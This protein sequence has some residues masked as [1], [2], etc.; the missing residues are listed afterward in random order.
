[1]RRQPMTTSELRKWQ[2]RIDRDKTF[3]TAH[4]DE[5][6]HLAD[7]AIAYA[8]K[9]E[10][11]RGGWVD[12]Y[13]EGAN[14]AGVRIAEKDREIKRLSRQCDRITAHRD[15]IENEN[16]Q[17]RTKLRSNDALLQRA[18]EIIGVGEWVG[19]AD[20]WLRDYESRMATDGDA[21]EEQ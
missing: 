16:D 19:D 2:K 21:R 7:V 8:E 12:G 15:V 20:Q 10:T 13:H 14:D 6:D 4:I 17:L 9:L 18:A 1:M 3:G 5:Y 11:Q